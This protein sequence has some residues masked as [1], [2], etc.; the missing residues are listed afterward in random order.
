MVPSA[1]RRTGSSSSESS[2]QTPG[3]TTLSLAIA[4]TLTA[5]RG[6]G[7]T[8]CMR[9]IVVR[10]MFP[11]GSLSRLFA[12]PLQAHFSTR[13]VFLPDSQLYPRHLPQGHLGSPLMSGARR[14]PRPYGETPPARPA[15]EGALWAATGN[16][17]GS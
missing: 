15:R 14:H 2:T 10:R 16:H 7:Q 9:G 1:C 12:P 13:N 6:G 17:H 4:A 8:R 3:G 11:C 5:S